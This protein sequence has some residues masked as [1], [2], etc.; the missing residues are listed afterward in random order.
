MKQYQMKYVLR[1]AIN[2]LMVD[3]VLSVL[4]RF[5]PNASGNLWGHR[6]PV[7]MARRNIATCHGQ[8]AFSLSF[9]MGV[10]RGNNSDEEAIDAC[11]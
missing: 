3:I 10:K 5:C 2:S 1:S 7:A 8:S 6:L 11:Q 4:S 9:F